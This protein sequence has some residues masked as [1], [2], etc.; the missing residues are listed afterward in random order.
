M[1]IN[2][3]ILIVNFKIIRSIAPG[4][5][6]IPTNIDVKT[7][8]PIWNENIPPTKFITNIIKPPNTEF[9]INLKIL[10]NGIKNIFPIINKKIMHPKNTI[11]EFIS[12]II[13]HVL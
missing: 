12:T 8:K 6:S 10:F 11:I 9:K 2:N 3:K 7:F 4:I 13:T 1:L 5:P